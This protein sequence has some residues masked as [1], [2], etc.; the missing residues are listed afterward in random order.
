MVSTSQKNHVKTVKYSMMSENYHF[1]RQIAVRCNRKYV[2]TEYAIAEIGI[3]SY[4][5]EKCGK[6]IKNVI[7]E[8]ALYDEYSIN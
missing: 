6:R 1:G 8:C 5:W 3:I 7:S 2:V 4:I